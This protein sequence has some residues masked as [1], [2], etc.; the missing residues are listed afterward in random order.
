MLDLGAAGSGAQAIAIGIGL[1][2]VVGV[3]VW[4]VRRRRSP[5]KALVQRLS[6]DCLMNV[7]IPD[8]LGG[9][10]YID[11][12][13]LTSEGLL[14]M[15]VVDV[16]GTVF[17]A[18]NLERWS[19]MATQGRVA[20]D[21]PLPGLANREAAVKLL[22][23]GIPVSSVVMFSRPV[24]FPKGRPEK[25]VTLQDLERASQNGSAESFASEWD[26]VKANAR[27]LGGNS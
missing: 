7:L 12:L 14:L 5:L 18:D 19:A 26:A 20:F 25:V 17:A 2:I 11:H 8:G 23:P 22:A 15:D 27:T 6:D 16:E 21:N 10:I 24:E 1:L 13:L 4:F 3:V 9:E